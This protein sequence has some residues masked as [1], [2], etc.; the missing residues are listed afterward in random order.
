MSSSELVEDTNIIQTADTLINIT[1]LKEEDK[2][3]F[4]SFF[5]NETLDFREVDF[6]WVEKK[7]IIEIN[8]S[9]VQKCENLVMIYLKS[10]Q[11][12]VLEKYTFQ[13]CINLVSVSFAENR[14]KELQ[15]ETFQQCKNLEEINFGSNQIENLY[16]I[17]FEKC[18]KLKKINFSSN[19]IKELQP[20]TFEYC[21]K[22][23]DIDFKYNKIDRIF[24]NTFHTLEE[25]QSVN[26]K[27]NQ[28]K[29]LDANTFHKCKNLINI[30]FGNNEIKKLHENL[31]DF[32][33]L[34]ESI[35]FE[36]NQINELPPK[37]FEKCIHLKEIYFD[38]N[39]IKKLHKDTFVKCAELSK[40]NFESNKITELHADTFKNCKHIKSICF[41]SNQIR[42]LE[43]AFSFDTRS[44]E[45][46]N[47]SFS[48]NFIQRFPSLDYSNENI[49]IDL[50][51]NVKI[52]DV[53]A[54][55]SRFNLKREAFEL[56]RSHLDYYCSQ[57]NGGE[58][59]GK[60][61]SELKVF[62]TFLF[63]DFDLRFLKEFLFFLN[64]N[65]RI[66][67]LREAD[68][69]NIKAE[70][71]LYFEKF[72]KFE[73]SLLDFLMVYVEKLGA[74][75]L[76][77]LN[78]LVKYELEQNSK[79]FLNLDFK[80]RSG[81]SV[82]ALCEFNKI[83]LFSKFFEQD[84]DVKNKSNTNN[85]CRIHDYETFYKSVNFENCFKIV[86]KKENEEVAIKLIEFLSHSINDLEINVL[87]EK[88]NEN[89]NH[90]FLNEI[91]V[92]FFKK[93]WWTAIEFLL[94]R[95]HQHKL[96][97]DAKLNR[98]LDGAK[99]L[100]NG[101]I[102]IELHK[103]FIKLDLTEFGAKTG[104]K[105]NQVA[106]QPQSKDTK[107]TEENH[108]LQLIKNITYKEQR[109]F[110]LKHATVKKLVN[111]KWI[112]I[113]RF[114]YYTNLLVFFLFLLF[115]SINIE[116]YA[117]RE[118]SHGLNVTCKLICF[119]ALGYFILH[120]L[121]QF[122]YNV[123]DK[124]RRKVY[125]SSFKHWL[126]LL[127]FLL[128]LVALVCDYSSSDI[129]L[130]S[131]LYSISILL[132]Y[133]TFA[134]RLDK[135]PKIGVY[136]DVIGKILSKSLTILVY[137]VIALIAFIL[138]FR[139]RSTFFKFETSESNMGENQMSH[140]NKTF[141]LNLFQLTKFSLGNL[142]TDDMGIEVI[143]EKTLVNYIIYACFI[144][145]MPIMFLNIFQSISIGEIQKLYED[146]EANEIRK[147]IEYIF[148]M[149]EI[150]SLPCLKSAVDRVFAVVGFFMGK[151]NYLTEK[152]STFLEKILIKDKS[153]KRESNATHS[154]EMS[155]DN[156]LV[157][158]I[159][160]NINQLT[161]R[162]NLSDQRME[163]NFED[164]NNRMEKMENVMEEMRELI[165]DKVENREKS[166][167]NQNPVASSKVNNIEQRKSDSES[168]EK[169]MEK[170]ENMLENLQRMFL[171]EM[172]RKK[173]KRQKKEQKA[174]S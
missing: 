65:K 28:I 50:R 89:F 135:L 169:R 31:F 101:E 46:N 42:I 94:N 105:P 103:P 69:E 131:S 156:N 29:E 61:L 86:V 118:K 139:N 148:L 99:D 154:K 140:F 168:S 43:L 111:D 157:K 32:E 71:D 121:L 122:I 70:F 102:K 158:D 63:R 130:K 38:S 66:Y 151:V 116:I 3:L 51:N 155:F 68:Y 164:I 27:F 161:S 72:K 152:I 93:E 95:I 45:C 75:N 108:I 52:L 110:F 5:K 47:F 2:K 82:K 124:Q 23:I 33:N 153:E 107:R 90:I 35:V 19:K 57:G 4:Q 171:E 109:N 120:K 37:L 53:Q 7:F 44:N 13:R 146:S 117:R 125:L 149:E 92:E 147:K 49:R 88:S 87:G 67:N 96:D 17:T 129:H 1:Q 166:I 60:T 11:I 20:K 167:L 132:A 24:S 76:I 163:Q 85:D 21:T 173:E 30:E 22:L 80:I 128:C 150:K 36:S 62:Q 34:I 97:Y 138:A 48:N 144:F 119:L 162:A 81:A 18:T 84:L 104:T 73:W 79:T 159:N 133:F 143:D 55:F 174:K 170:M 126:E 77:N 83:E 142:E 59:L 112:L 56:S 9:L 141:E 14:I 137:L 160:G 134:S 136:I 54:F 98:R 64:F 25:L 127:A 58:K 39:R 115:Y 165:E 78:S 106:P 8:V 12:E 15:P 145:I 114:F 74:D 41:D 123:A 10:N 113:P 172:N 26:F 100:E 6:L 16:P 40:I 91:L